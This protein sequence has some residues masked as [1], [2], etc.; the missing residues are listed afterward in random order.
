ME[1]GFGGTLL[2]GSVDLQKLKPELRAKIAAAVTM[3]DGGTDGQVLAKSGTGVVWTDP[4]ASGGGGSIAVD[5]ADP[6]YLVASGGGIA[7]DP[8]DPD[9][10]TFA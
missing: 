6:D 1:L 3:P 10:L 2:D 8:A 5:P 7:P 9:Y 4:P